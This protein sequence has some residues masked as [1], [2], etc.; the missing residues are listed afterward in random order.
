MFD[1]GWVL[2][3]LDEVSRSTA[4]PLNA[5][6][7]RL[8]LSPLVSAA[9]VDWG[10][11][12]SASAIRLAANRTNIAAC[13]EKVNVEGETRFVPAIYRQEGST[14]RPAIYRPRYGRSNPNR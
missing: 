2:A 6:V 5:E 3:M 12:T 10:F 9:R 13:V 1:D 4:T 14:V 11:S 7:E 8:G